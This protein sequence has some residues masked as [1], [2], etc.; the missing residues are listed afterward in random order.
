MEP[1]LCPA[2]KVTRDEMK[3]QSFLAFV[4]DTFRRHPNLPAFKI[5]PPTGWSPTQTDMELDGMVIA[6]PI[7]Q[8]VRMLHLHDMPVLAT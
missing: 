5:V 8:L 1:P 3:E 2:F 6:T 7:Q 4:K